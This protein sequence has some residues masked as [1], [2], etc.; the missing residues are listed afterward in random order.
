MKRIIIIG[1]GQTEQSFCSAV[2]QPHFNKYSIYI[3]N[4]VIK[5]T[6]GGIVHWPALK[7]QV[8]LHL[9][10]DKTA[11]VTTLID[12]YG[13]HAHHKYPKWEEAQTMRNMSS[14]MYAIENAMLNDV[15]E[16]L[17]YRFIPYIQLHEFEA[18]IFCDADVFDMYYEAN[19]ADLNQL[20]NICSTNPNPEDINNS[21]VTAPSKRLMQYIPGY[22]K[23]TDGTQLL[24]AI[25]LTTIRNKCPRFNHW[26]ETLET[27]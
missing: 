21:P 15:D 16:G 24:M 26:I 10:Q 3:Q 6:S 18:L 13:I 8:Q 27:I 12:Y 2:L 7:H 5:K 1:E 19:E 20:K 4:P 9:R 22:N 25:G 14:A 17:R 23:I 11:F